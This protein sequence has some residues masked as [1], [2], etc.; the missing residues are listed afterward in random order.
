[1]CT[2]WCWNVCRGTPRKGHFRKKKL[3]LKLLDSWLNREGHGQGAWMKGLLQDDLKGESKAQITLGKFSLQL[4]SSEGY[5]AQGHQICWKETAFCFS[6][7]IITLS[8]RSTAS[9]PPTA[10]LPS[11]LSSAHQRF[12]EPDI[13]LACHLSLLLEVKCSECRYGGLER[14]LAHLLSH[15]TSAPPHPLLWGLPIPRL[16]LVI[17]LDLDS[18]ELSSRTNATSFQEGLGRSH[19]AI[20]PHA[21]WRLALYLPTP[22]AAGRNPG[23]T[24]L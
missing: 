1:M 23:T 17:F 24:E 14:A 2:A 13:Y 15:G 19:R 9:S 18:R 22:G 4:I 21:Q 11:K 20:A 8:H 7:E 5:R 3:L 10:R 16:V 12:F 6:W